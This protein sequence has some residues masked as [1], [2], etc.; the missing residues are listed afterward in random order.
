MMVVYSWY[1]IMIRLDCSDWKIHNIV[2]SR[3]GELTVIIFDPRLTI[4]NYYNREID[5]LM[6][7]G[8]TKDLIFSE[9]FCII[10]SKTV[11]I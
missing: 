8:S 4:T 7:I 2:S 11:S 6:F 10:D 9:M 1:N 3:D 5:L